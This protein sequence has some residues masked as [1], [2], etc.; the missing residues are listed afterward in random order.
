MAAPQ[1]SPAVVLNIDPNSSTFTCVGY[2]PSR[3]RRCRNPIACVNRQESVKTLLKMSR[4]DPHSQRVDDELEELAS[5]LLCKRWHQDQAAAMKRQWRHNIASYQCARIASQ[6]QQSRTVRTRSAPAPATAAQA[7]AMSTERG[8][9]TSVVTL[10]PT[11]SYRV[12]VT[13][14]I[15]ITEE[16]EVGENNEPNGNREGERENNESTGDRPEETSI[17][18]QSE[19]VETNEPHERSSEEHVTEAPVQQQAREESLH[20]DGRR[21]ID[22]DCSICQEDLHSGADTVWCRA[23]CRQNFHEACIDLWH[24]SQEAGDRRKTCPYW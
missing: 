11:R 24:A 20:N 1:W 7:S 4:L 12:S 10:Q 23:Q 13:I 5:R 3:G 17:T 15:A 22:G 8:R 21:A 2:A 18:E 9:T 16:S 14:S 19:E 6:P